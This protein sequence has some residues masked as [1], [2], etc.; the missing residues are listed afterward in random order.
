MTLRIRGHVGWLARCAV[1]VLA[2]ATLWGCKGPKR[3]DVQRVERFA[4]PDCGRGPLP[5]GELL[6]SGTLRP[7]VARGGLPYVEHYEIRKRDCL[8]VA[9]ARIETSLELTDLEVVYDAAGKPLRVWRR[10]TLAVTPS[11]DGKPDIALYELRGDIPTLIHR[12]PDGGLEYQTL[13]GG[14]PVAVITRARG[15]LTPWIRGA[16]LA[17][18]DSVHDVVIDL[19]TPDL[20]RADVMLRREADLERPELG[21]RVRVYTVYGREA[22]FTDETGEVIGDLSGLV[23][24]ERASG[25]LPAPQPRY[26]GPDPVH[27]P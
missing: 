3:R 5:E 11:A 4:Y 1:A 27:T 9:T 2:A 20:I 13:G 7:A 18:G 10:N 19:D 14:R 25:P 21:G 26:G 12:R 15:L 22:V 24:S 8:V 23:P 6:A 16:D 17:P